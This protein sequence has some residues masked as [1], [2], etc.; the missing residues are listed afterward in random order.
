MYLQ[1]SVGLTVVSADCAGQIFLELFS[2]IVLFILATK[3][4]SKLASTPIATIRDREFHS[5]TATCGRM[6]TFGILTSIVGSFPILLGGFGT[7]IIGV[8]V[9]NFDFSI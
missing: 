3:T 8:I 6:S 9:R 5:H 2:G 4:V 7:R 1:K